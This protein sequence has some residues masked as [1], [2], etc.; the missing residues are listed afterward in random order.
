MIASYPDT[1]RKA[2]YL[3]FFLISLWAV[4]LTLK[5]D[6]FWLVGLGLFALFIRTMYLIYLNE[7]FTAFG[8]HCVACLLF[9]FQLIDTS[10]IYL[11]AISDYGK[12]TR[13]ATSL[14]MIPV[15]LM[16]VEFLFIYFTKPRPGTTI[17]EIRENRIC[18]ESH[19]SSNR[20]IN[21][22]GGCFTAVGAASMIGWH[23]EQIVL[24]IIA[25][26]LINL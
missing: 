13:D 16:L 22:I 17:F 1:M 25:L 3:P 5:S 4:L 20:I 26:A 23:V 18:M 11:V 2:L 24:A 8:A 19:H 12:S 10:L 15:L 9:L 7:R 21:I 14:A 6:L